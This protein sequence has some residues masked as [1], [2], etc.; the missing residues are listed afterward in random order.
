[1]HARNTLFQ[2]GNATMLDLNDLRLFEKVAALKSFSA[3]A[4]ALELP[5][6]SIS[7]AITRLESELG[8]RLFQRTTRDVTLTDIGAAFQGRCVDILSRVGE[9]IDYVTSLA[10]T[11]RG[12]LNISAGIGFGVNV[13]S[14][15]LPRFI[16]RYPDISVH[17]DLS[18]RAADLVADGIDIAIRMGPMPASRVVAKRLGSIRRYL[19]ASPDYVR[20]CGLPHSVADLRTHNAVEMPAVEG[21]P[22]IWVFSNA[23]R[24]PVE[25][26]P[27]VRIVVNDALTIHR[28]IVNGAGIGCVSGYLCNPDFAAGRLVPLLPDWTLPSV[29]VSVVFPSHRELAPAVRAFVDFIKDAS[30]PGKSW[31]DDD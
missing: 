1:M 26:E 6:S 16:E 19:C 8:A 25:V 3:A 29:E 9:T 12:R 28:L 7:R 4:R 30:Q 21:R 14:E 11:P 2:Q 13:L 23:K 24:K 5:K 31:Q 18:S 20:R 27:R 15:L 17:L 22:R 10:G